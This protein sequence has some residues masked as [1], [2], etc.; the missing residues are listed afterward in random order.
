MAAHLGRH[1]AEAPGAL[2]LA[3]V[4]GLPAGDRRAMVGAHL[5]AL[6]DERRGPDLVATLATWVRCGYAS[7]RTA[8]ALGVH[9]HTLDYRLGRIRA[10]I[11]LDLDSPVDRLAVELALFVRGD[12]RG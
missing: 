9:R 3:A 2:G 12:L 4:L 7:A 11:G 8:R 6:E 5:D 10:R 1:H